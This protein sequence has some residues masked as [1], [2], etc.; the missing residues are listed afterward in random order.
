MLCRRALDLTHIRG[1]KMNVCCRYIIYTVASE[2]Y[3]R[4]ASPKPTRFAITRDESSLLSF[5]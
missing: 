1:E 4:P 5:R 2:A 3:P